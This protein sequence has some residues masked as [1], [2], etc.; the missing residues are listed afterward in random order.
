[1][2]MHRW[3]MGAAAIVALAAC[4][5]ATDATT[6]QAPPGYTSA[7]S[8]GPFVQVW[9]GASTRSA[10]VLMA[11]PTE[12]DY[13]DVTSESNVKD[14][15]ILKQG[16]VKIC[17]NQDAHYYSMVGDV[18]VENRTSPPPDETSE[19]QQID[20]IA[21]HLNGKTYLA[22]YTRPKGSTEDSAAEAAIKNICPRG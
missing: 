15:E 16:P 20:V 17:G 6:F 5:S 19:R 21:T 13:K 11:L 12:I 18:D 1:M 22:M 7:V 9:R 14:A 10:I 8:V 2:S 3:L 4:G